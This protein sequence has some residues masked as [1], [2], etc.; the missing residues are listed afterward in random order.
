VA[1]SEYVTSLAQ[2][3]NEKTMAEFS[4]YQ[5]R[6]AWE[7]FDVT[8]SGTLSTSQLKPIFLKL[9]RVITDDELADM[10]D[11]LDPDATGAVNYQTF[12]WYLSRKKHSIEDEIRETFRSFDKD[13]S[14][15]I[16]TA[17]LRQIMMNIGENLTDEEVDEMVRES[18]AESSGVINYVKFV[19]NLVN[20]SAEHT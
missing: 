6:D 8:Q 2:N 12:H 18:Q 9:N 19:M 15:M 1:V 16:P 5:I 11:E 17:E 10:L 20:K 4:D 13:G 3:Y 7:T 14:G